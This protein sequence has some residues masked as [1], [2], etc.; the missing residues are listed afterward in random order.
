MGAH[1]DA[2]SNLRQLVEQLASDIPKLQSW[3]CLTNYK[4]DSLDVYNELLEI[5][6]H[7]VFRSLT[8]EVV[9]Q[10]TMSLS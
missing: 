3:L 6:T 5:M 2:E 8:N 9:K 1:G 7:C 4:C 10:G